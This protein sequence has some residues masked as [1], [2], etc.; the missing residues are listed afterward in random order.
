MHTED[1]LTTRGATR[2]QL[3]PRMWGSLQRP[4]SHPRS[5]LIRGR[6]AETATR[7]AGSPSPL[8]TATHTCRKLP[9]S[10]IRWPEGLTN[11]KGSRTV[12]ILLYHN[13]AT[14]NYYQRFSYFS[15]TANSLC[16]SFS[17][18]TIIQEGKLRLAGVTSATRAVSHLAALTWLRHSL[19]SRFRDP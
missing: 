4:N 14:M 16:S 19:G 1:R 7:T 10:R 11:N 15:P 13:N 5:A 3:C 12:D 2:E 9:K 17:S 6:E 18:Y 8:L